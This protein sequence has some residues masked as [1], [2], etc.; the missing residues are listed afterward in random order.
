M[1]RTYVAV[2]GVVALVAAGCGSDDKPPTKAAYIA[3]ADPICTAGKAKAKAFTDKLDALPAD[4]QV[5]DTV[6]DLQGALAASRDFAT[7]LRKLERPKED[8][9]I[10]DSY[11]ASLAQALT[12]GD[13]LLAAAK[14]NDL[15]KV[16]QV[17]AS[18]PELKAERKRIAK[19]FGFKHCA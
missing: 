5:K 10:L 16:Q 19:Q 17:G 2:L 18:N 11:F 7:K 15:A 8:K 9:A 4:A 14:T 12:A 3:K 1:R 6:P 13:R